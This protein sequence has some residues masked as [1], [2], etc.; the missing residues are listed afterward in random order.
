MSLIDVILD[1]ILNPWFVLS[2][3][4]WLIVL[5]LVYLLRNKKGATYLFFPLLAMFKTRRLNNFIKKVSR[6]APKFWKYFW[7]VGIFISF[8]FTIFAFYFF[9]SNFINLIIN[10]RIE[11]AI[12]LLIP[13]VTIN[14]PMFSYL[15]LP[16]LF[17]VTTHEFAHGISASADGVEIK[18]TGVLGAGL[19]FIIGFGAFVE[20]DE[21]E[22][23]SSKFHRNTRLRIAAAGTYVNAITTGVAFLLI[24]SFPLIISPF[25]VQVSQVHSVIPETDGGFNEGKLSAGDLILAIKKQGIGDEEYISLDNYAGRTLSNILNNGTSL[26]CSI[27]D[28]LTLRVYNPSTDSY[29]EKN[30]TLA[31]RYYL[32]ILYEYVSDT[33]LQITRIY[34]EI[35]GGNNYNKN[36]TVGLNITEVNGIPINQTSGDTL[37]KALA[38]FNLNTI[39]ISSVSETFI[40]DVN[41]TGVAIG[42]YTNLYFMHKNAIAKFFTSFWP[43]F[44][45]KEIFWLFVI[46]FSIT[47]FNL[48]PLPVFDGDRIVKELLNWGFG[49]DYRTKKKK[50]DKVLF[51]KDDNDIQL[52]EYRVE[53]VDSVK[54]IIKNQLDVKEQSEIILAEDKYSLVDKI[55]DGFKDTISLNLP[56][57]TKLKEG[58]LFEISYEY[59]YDEKRKIKRNILNSLRLITLFI[60]VGSLILSFIKF[61]A[62]FFWI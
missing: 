20:V 45:F 43:D 41:V 50:T 23:N 10:P 42:I 29:S 35:E 4:F 1:F 17:I 9:F 11:Q 34:S 36:L 13:G 59:W 18:S 56:E 2:L 51:T 7:T 27:G 55:G 22:L 46:A 15:I 31:P 48:L 8:G 37:G 3:I 21:R 32:G 30:V 25:Y 19:F 62:I 60:V 6:K 28:N 40:L 49:E 58:S 57:Q 47:L 61:G 44:W 53:K 26:K 54:L 5:L 52:S 24:L 14:L 16:I 39:N 33:K 12:V 38:V